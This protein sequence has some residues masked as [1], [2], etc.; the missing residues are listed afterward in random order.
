MGYTHYWDVHE[1]PEEAFGRLAMDAKIIFEA[2]AERGIKL[3]NGMGAEGSE[4]EIGEGAIV[5]NGE[6]PNDYETFYFSQSQRGFQFC[7]TARNPYDPIVCAV[8]IRA[9]VHYGDGIKV[10][11]DGVWDANDEWQPAAKLV[12]ELFG[13]ANDPT[14][15]AS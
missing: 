3:A 8:L 11:S 14:V 10:S 2:A 1:E 9:K 4:P 13:E 7:K 6:E 12:T 5:F 15:G